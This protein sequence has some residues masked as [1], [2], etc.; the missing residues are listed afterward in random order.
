M[1]RWG[2]PPAYVKFAS[3]ITQDVEREQAISDAA[4]VAYSTAVETSQVAQ[5]GNQVLKG[6]V[7]ISQKMVTN[8]TGYEQ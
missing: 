4:N 3:D 2:L 7:T 5:E 6:T 1:I 8:L